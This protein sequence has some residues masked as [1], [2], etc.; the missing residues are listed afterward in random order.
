M[1]TSA[2]TI[3]GNGN[4]ISRSG[5]PDFRILAVAG[6]GNLTLNSATVSGGIAGGTFQRYLWRRHLQPLR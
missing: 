3:E 6:G 4:T 2:I 5:S 1:I